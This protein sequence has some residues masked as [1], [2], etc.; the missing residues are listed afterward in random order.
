MDI[1]LEVELHIT[2][3][4]CG[5][6][7]NGKHRFGE[8]KAGCLIYV[9]PCKNCTGLATNEEIVQSDSIVRI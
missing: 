9:E 4:V 7:L 3:S 2:C 8:A 5:Q 1:N 6:D